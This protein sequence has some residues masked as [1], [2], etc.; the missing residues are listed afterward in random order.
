MRKSLIAVAAFLALSMFVAAGAADYVIPNRLAKA[1]AG[2]WTLMQTVAGDHMGEKIRFSVKSVIGV[3]EDAVV[4]IANERL[5]ADGAVAEVDEVE[6][7]LSRY[8]A[9]LRELED[10][11]KQ[12]SRERLTIGDA[13]YT[14]YAVTW[15]DEES[16]RE[17][18]IWISD[19][20][21]V[22]GLMKSWSSDAAFPAVELV[23]FGPR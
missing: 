2:E 8:A 12:V 22:G 15:D 9:K 23:D 21:P 4:L 6:V 17:M 10:N 3:G 16:G 5:D 20:I 7:P 19:D 11:A 14:V 18:K 1:V 13:A